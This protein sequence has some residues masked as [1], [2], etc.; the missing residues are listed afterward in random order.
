VA[1]W[2]PQLLRVW[3]VWRDR[4]TCG[5]DGW[6]CCRCLLA[7]TVSGRSKEAD[8]AKVET[9]RSKLKRLAERDWLAEEAG[10]GLFGLPSRNGTGEAAEP[11]R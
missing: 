10:P 6:G 11:G 4:L 7:S 9:L 2:L 8:K 1:P 3:L 5:V